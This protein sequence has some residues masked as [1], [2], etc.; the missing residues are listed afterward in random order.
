MRIKKRLILTLLASFVLMVLFQN[1]AKKNLSELSSDL[2]ECIASGRQDC[3]V[4]G[5]SNIK[6]I[7]LNFIPEN[8]NVVLYGNYLV[9]DGLANN[10]KINFKSGQA[11]NVSSG[12]NCNISNSSTWLQIKN[13]Y[14]VNGVCN[15]SYASLGNMHCMAL[16]M[17]FGAIEQDDVRTITELSGSMCLN[18]HNTVCGDEETQALFARSFKELHIELSSSR[19]CN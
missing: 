14:E 19:S 12:Q 18:S 8:T 2:D 4:G 1:C 13:L 10:Y 16:P 17:P 11:M 3:G 15:Y 6:V 5:Y 9:E 7:N